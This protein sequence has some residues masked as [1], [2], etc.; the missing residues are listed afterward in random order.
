MS[1]SVAKKEVQ[2]AGE[3]SLLV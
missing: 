2:F 1:K 3:E